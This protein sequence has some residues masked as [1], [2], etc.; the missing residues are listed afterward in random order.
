MTSG[1]N[2]SARVE[3]RARRSV[4]GSPLGWCG[5]AGSVPTGAL[6]LF[7]ADWP[8]RLTAYGLASPLFRFRLSSSVSCRRRTAGVVVRWYFRY[9]FDRR[10]FVLG[11]WFVVLLLLLLFSGVP[12][13][14]S[15]RD[16]AATGLASALPKL[17]IF[18]G[19]EAVGE[20]RGYQRPGDTD[21][22]PSRAYRCQ[23]QAGQGTE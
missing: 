17:H 22:M 15:E 20:G 5:L 1:V 23:L 16:G 21:C 10:S 6:R 9:C 13:P 8:N 4:T 11:F 14:N 7:P 18:G 3:R 2:N 19:V 12:S